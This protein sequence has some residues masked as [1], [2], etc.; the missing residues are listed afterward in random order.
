MI[1]IFSDEKEDMDE[2]ANDHFL[3]KS[4]KSSEISTSIEALKVRISM[5]VAPITEITCAHHLSTA[6]FKLFDYLSK[7]RNISQLT[8]EENA[9]TIYNEDGSIKTSSIKKI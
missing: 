7:N 1:N 6:V 4:V 5:Y 3:F 2:K 8:S 9:P